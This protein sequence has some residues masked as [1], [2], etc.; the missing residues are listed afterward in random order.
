MGLYLLFALAMIPFVAPHFGRVP[1]P[2]R[3]SVRPLS[4]LTVI[5]NR[6]YVSPELKQQMIAISETMDRKYPGTKLNYLDANFPFFDGFPLL[7]HL[8]HNDGKK[9]D[10][11]FYYKVKSNGESTNSSPS[12]IGYGAFEAPKNSEVNYPERCRMDGFMMYNFL[13]VIEPLIQKEKYQFDAERTRKLVKLLAKDAGVSKIFIEPHLKSRLNL[14]QYDK[15]RFQGC[16]SVRHD[17]HIH[18]QIF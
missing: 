11:A 7:P 6:H 15:I 8:S 17:D 9:I 4:I 2:T 16:H 18:A 14:Q 12:F 1:L 10:L 13:E 3:G 5:L